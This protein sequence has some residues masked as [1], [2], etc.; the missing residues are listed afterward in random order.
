MYRTDRQ[1]AWQ[2]DLAWASAV[3]LAVS[4]AVGAALFSLAR[5]SGPQTG[6]DLIE[7]VV[8]L[9]LRPGDGG[10]A[11]GVSTLTEY[12]AGERLRL[13]PG[14]D[15][16]ADATEIPAF[17]AE[18]AV[19]RGAGVLSDE[20]VTGGAAAVLA[21]VTDPALSAQLELALNG[22]I[23]ALVNADL[24]RELL[25]AGLDD[26]TRLANWPA[27]AA[28]NPGEPVQPIVGVFVT[29]PPRELQGATNREIGAAVVAALADE[30]TQGGLPQAL[31]VVTN[32]NLRARLTRAVDTSFRAQAHELF[33][34][35]LAGY[36]STMTMRLAEASSVLAG[37]ADVEGGSLSGL[38]PASALAG[39]T[40]E[41]AD[42]RI[43]EAL[44]ERAYGAGGAAAAQ[45]LTGAGQAQRVR[46][47]APLIDAFG[48]AAHRRYLVYTYLAGAVTLLLI[49]ALVAF[50][51]GFQRLVNPGIAIVIGAAPLAYALDRVR[52]WVTP[53]AALPAG[54][55]AEGVPATLTGLA[56]YALAALP[57]AAVSGPLRYHVVLLLVGAAL[58]VLALLLWLLRGLRP[59]R[60]G[61]R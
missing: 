52:T 53:N 21:S 39:L 50:S 43:I 24:S 38:L 2:R 26:G 11:V 46:R 17:T 33:S 58:V 44:A 16:Y 57:P 3:L 8:R 12:R 60:R 61:Y 32:D 13:L 36:A 30:V 27:Q 7:S 23:A 59:R 56:A 51:R 25:G 48:S 29:F 5:S 35:V 45:Q 28:A 54:A 6:V 34:A 55:G 31:A 37:A 22:P 15:V 42:A 1:P 20:F 47:V 14:L 10:V 4:V 18:A 41:Q 49:A 40:A 9:T 19:N